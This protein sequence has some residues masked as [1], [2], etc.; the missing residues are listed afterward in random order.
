MRFVAF[1]ECDQEKIQEFIE[2]WNKRMAAHHNIVTVFPPHTIADAPRGFKGF[3]VF[4]T[5]CIEDI[6]H[7]VT[8]YGQVAKVQ[9]FPIWDATEG[10]K[11]YEKIKA[12]L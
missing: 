2:I 8:E 6:M 3:T 9:V 7:Y 4:E 1:L 10:T 5:D 11:L 12:G